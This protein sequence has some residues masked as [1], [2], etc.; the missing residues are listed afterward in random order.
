MQAFSFH[1]PPFKCVSICICPASQIQSSENTSKSFINWRAE[2]GGGIARRQFFDADVFEFDLRAFRFEREITFAVVAIFAAG[3][4]LAVHAESQRAVGADDSIMIPF[5]ETFAPFFGRETAITIMAAKRFHFRAVDRKD[6]AVR[7][8]PLI[9]AGNIEAVVENLDFDAA[10][11]GDAGRRDGRAPNEYA[12]IPAAFEKMPV[13]FQ[14]EVFVLAFGSHRAGRMTGAMDHAVGDRPGFRRA[15]RVYPAS[16][17][18]AVEERRK[19]FFIFSGERGQSKQRHEQKWFHGGS[20]N[21]K[22][23]FGNLKFLL[24]DQS[25]LELSQIFNR[26]NVGKLAQRMDGQLRG[27]GAR[28]G[29]FEHLGTAPRNIFE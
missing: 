19:T 8:V 23:A 3:N 1:R 6:I 17:I 11:K 28:D 12:R 4:F 29:G 7:C 27:S 22:S 20:M 24:L 2:V 13:R 26:I 14:N 9:L 5:R 25:R 15:I 10:Q 18:T 16:E 21:P